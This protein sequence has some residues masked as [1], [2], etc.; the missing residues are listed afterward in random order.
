MSQRP[1]ITSQRIVLT[2]A[3]SGIGEQLA[4][5]LAAAG[6]RLLLVA[7]REDRLLELQV[8]FDGSDCHVLA[9]DISH[10]ETRAA[11][12]AWVAA[13]WGGLDVLVNNAG[14]GAVGPFLESDEECLRQIF[15]V[16]LF[17]P[18][19]LIRLLTPLLQGQ[20]A[21][22]IVNIGSVLGHFAA[23]GKSEYCA[24][25]FALHG[26]T[27]SLRAELANSGIHVLMV[28]PSTTRSEF[29]DQ[30]R[31]QSAKS[32]F[33]FG[34]MSAEAVAKLTIRALQKR[35]REVILSL[36]GKALV[37]LDRLCPPMMAWLQ[38]RK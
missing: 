21:P 24:S 26:F 31:T 19:E 22:A 3:S 34:A 7:R 16:N 6:A 36:G 10:A 27:D 14:I 11:I 8:E 20:T 18:L 33:K 1:P 30:H 37:W 35:K 9:G 12:H 15:E 23:A 28:S 29:F 32:P 17:A 4:R 2:G 38:R 13:Q 25:K 5:Q